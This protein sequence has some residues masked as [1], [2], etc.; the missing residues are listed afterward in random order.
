LAQG[1]DLLLHDAQYTAE[2]FPARRHYGHSTFDYAVGLARECGV[3][4]LLLFHHDPG[5]TDEQLDQIVARLQ[6]KAG[7]SVRVEAASE[8]SEVEV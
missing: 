6:E 1:A 4:R 7:G 5:R 2:E 3:P 8:G